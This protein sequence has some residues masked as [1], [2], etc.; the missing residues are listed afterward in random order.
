[1]IKG[2][3]KRIIE[4]N[5]T[6]NSYIEK[7]ILIINPDTSENEQTKITNEVSEYFT[8]LMSEELS[9]PKKINHK[10]KISPALIFSLLVIT[11]IIITVIV[12]M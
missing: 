5:D 12:L 9:P 11:A 10:N 8:K 6:N 1:M 3:N 4:I 2:I 7:A